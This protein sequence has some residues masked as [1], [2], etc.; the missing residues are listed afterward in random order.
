MQLLQSEVIIAE[1]HIILG[2]FATSKN[3][4]D[5]ADFIADYVVY[6]VLRKS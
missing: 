5:P 3:V 4:S 1:W 2:A 6:V